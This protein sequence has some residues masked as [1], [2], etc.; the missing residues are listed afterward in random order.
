MRT[1]WQALE[2]YAQAYFLYTLNSSLI[3]SSYPVRDDFIIQDIGNLPSVD[4]D[5][6][7]RD[8]ELQKEYSKYSH[9]FRFDAHRLGRKMDENSPY[10][11]GFEFGVGI[12]PEIDKE[13]KNNLQLQEVK[14]KTNECNQKNDLFN[15][16]LKMAGHGAMLDNKC[17]LHFIFDAQRPSSWGADAREL[18]TVLHVE[19]HK[20]TCNALPFFWIEEGLAMRFIYWW[21]RI[22]SKSRFLR[23]DNRLL[24]WLGEGLTHVLKKRIV[25]REKLFGYYQQ[26]VKCE[27]GTLEN[28]NV[29]EKR[30]FVLFRKAYANRYATD[31]FRSFIE[32][33]A[34]QNEIAMKDFPTFRDLYSSA[35]QILDQGGHFGQELV[36]YNTRTTE[37]PEKPDPN[38]EYEEFYH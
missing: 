7:N 33:W 32:T 30:Y 3:E 8:P 25:R 10:I 34:E 22:R 12:V 5:Y 6:L 2:I 29:E 15:Q 24:T 31:Y 28:E 13:Y 27:S 4:T 17:Y 14:S 19:K 1:I 16:W 36:K 18:T 11:G 21:R 20:E 26:N 35:K 37:K 23:G 9:N 38:V